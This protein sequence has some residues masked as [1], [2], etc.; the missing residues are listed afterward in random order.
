MGIC[1]LASELSRKIPTRVKTVGGIAATAF[2][3]FFLSNMPATYASAQPNDGDRSG[4][5]Q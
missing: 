5:Q 1:E 4:D 3:S 2:L